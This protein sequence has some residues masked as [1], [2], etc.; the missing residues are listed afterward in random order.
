MLQSLG[1]QKVGRDL[2]SKQQ[3]T[4]CLY[5]EMFF[6]H[7]LN[8]FLFFNSPLI[9]I[10]LLFPIKILFSYSSFYVNIILMPLTLQFELIQDDDNVCLFWY[11]LGS[12]NRSSLT[13]TTEWMSGMKFHIANLP[14]P[15]Y[16]NREGN[17]KNRLN[18]T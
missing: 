6:L 9:L 2:A 16:S 18:F 14:C 17:G 7:S 4:S 8:F 10:L 15:L 11:P 3:F 1:S 13:P 5:S 12:Q